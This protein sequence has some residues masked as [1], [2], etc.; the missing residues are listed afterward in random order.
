MKIIS[1]VFFVISIVLFVI[2]AVFFEIS[3]RYMRKQNERKKKESTKLGI[4]F[5][6]YGSIA[7]GISGLFA[8][9]S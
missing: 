8:F 2:A 5:L 1:N 3:L 4:R 9:F 6:I 7:F